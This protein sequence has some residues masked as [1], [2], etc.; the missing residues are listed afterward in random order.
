MAE[1]FSN[2]FDIETPAGAEKW[3]DLYTYS[4]PFS[5]NQREYEDKIFWFQ[6]KMH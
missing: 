5:E 4:L 2:P 1:R 6:D 3:E